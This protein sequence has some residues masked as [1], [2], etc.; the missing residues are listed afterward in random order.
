[1][2]P[3]VLRFIKHDLPA[4][5]GCFRLVFLQATSALSWVVPWRT[6]PEEERAGRLSAGRHRY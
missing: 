1:M 3:E 5:A 4:V 2:R 6:P